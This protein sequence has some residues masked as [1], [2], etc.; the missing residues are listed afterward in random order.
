MISVKDIVRKEG[1]HVFRKIVSPAEVLKAKKVLEFQ[2]NLSDSEKDILGTGYKDVYP[3]YR[4]HYYTKMIPAIVQSGYSEFGFAR[5]N[6]FLKSIDDFHQVHF[7]EIGF[8]FSDS[9]YILNY[10]NPEMC[11]KTKFVNPD[12][13]VFYTDIVSFKTNSEF[14]V[15]LTN[16]VYTYSE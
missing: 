16:F 12:D 3:V 7:G 9:P 10:I 1:I 14:K 4:N 11:L 2:N 6:F 8:L 5:N 13:M 15:N